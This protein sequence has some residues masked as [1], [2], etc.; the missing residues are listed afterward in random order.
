MKKYDQEIVLKQELDIRRIKNK[1]WLASR[2]LKKALER[3]IKVL[4]K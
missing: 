2:I 1:R 4:E 3:K